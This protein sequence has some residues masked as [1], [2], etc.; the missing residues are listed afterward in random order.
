MTSLPI[1]VGVGQTTVHWA[2]PEDGPAPSPV[3]LAASAVRTAID[4]CGVDLS[5]HIARLYCTRLMQDSLPGIA[6]PETTFEDLPASI[7]D[8]A[9]LSHTE[10]YY[11]SVGGDQPQVLLH[12]AAADLLENGGGVTVLTGAEATAA[13][14]TARRQGCALNWSLEATQ[15]T[16]DLGWGDS[17]ITPYELELGLGLPMHCYGLLEHAVRHRYGWSIADYH[18]Q[19]GGLLEGLSAVAADNSNA[20]FP[21]GMDR[22]FLASPTIG[23]PPFTDLYRKWSMAQ[24]SVNQGAAVIVTT[25]DTARALGID[26]SRWVYLHTHAAALD[27]PIVHRADWS[28]SSAMRAVIDTVQR[29]SGKTLAELDALD[30]YS[31]FPAVVML[32][33]EYL[34]LPDGVAT[35]ITGGLPFFGG[36][37]N[38]YVMHAIATMAERLR[39]QPD[40]SGL[41]L[42]TGGYLSKL[43]AAIYSAKPPASV[44]LGDRTAQRLVDAEPTVEIDEHLDEG[45][46]DGYCVAYGREGPTHAF[47]SVRGPT[48]RRLKVERE[49]KKLSELTGADWIGEPVS[50]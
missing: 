26:A 5:T 4:D 18:A 30:L 6:S 40:A 8:A 11:S 9:G 15:R 10:T 17:I 45:V 16:T 41:V 7:A 50:W 46:I 49:S 24:E 29:Q 32:A 47:V 36:P 43:S 20:F 14:K 12:Q 38:N 39:E 22:D 28:H 27:R 1:I 13:I 3:S 35:S 37:G 23:N 2:G 48:G 25:T 31:C 33:K 34:G 44:Q 42:G 19:A 21:K